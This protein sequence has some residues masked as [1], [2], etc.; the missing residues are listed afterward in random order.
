MSLLSER[1]ISGQ[2]KGYW[3][4]GRNFTHPQTKNQVGF[5]SLPLEEQKRLNDMVRKNTPEKFKP[6]P[7][8]PPEQEKVKPQPQQEVV[9]NV[10]PQPKEKVKPQP[11]EKSVKPQPKEKVK[12]QPKE[13]PVPEEMSKGEWFDYKFGKFPKKV[14]KQIIDGEKGFASVEQIRLQTD[15]EHKE[16]VQKA[17]SKGLIDS[18]PDYPE[19]KKTEAPPVGKEEKPKLDKGILNTI[20]ERLS[21][22][23]RQNLQNLLKTLHIRTKEK[24]VEDKEKAKRK[25]EKEFKDKHQKGLMSLLERF[26]FDKKEMKIVSDIFSHI[27]STDPNHA[28]A[29][30]EYLEGLEEDKSMRGM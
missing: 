20:M 6:E 1:D 15:R 12:P 17:I 3:W 23:K 30:M 29:L 24:G 5:K 28:I 18:H 10:K 14:Q 4:E 11:K 16:N 8:R 19:L 26:K 2:S 25:K 22:A 21:P 7:S 27:Y 13:K 9:P